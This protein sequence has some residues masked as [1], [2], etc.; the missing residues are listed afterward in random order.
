MVSRNEPYDIL[1]LLHLFLLSNPKQ[2]II[3]G[4]GKLYVPHAP[5][6][7]SSLKSPTRSRPQPITFEIL[8]P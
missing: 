7:K 6:Q 8:K 2:S 4:S 1:H 3:R 5:L